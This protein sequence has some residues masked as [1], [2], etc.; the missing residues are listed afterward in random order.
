MRGSFI[1]KHSAL[2]TGGRTQKAVRIKKSPF[3]HCGIDMNTS[4]KSLGFVLGNV[5]WQTLLH[6]ANKNEKQSVRYCAIILIQ[7]GGGFE[8]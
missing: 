6:K 3:N 1:R 5:K 4:D 8:K 2:K 7:R